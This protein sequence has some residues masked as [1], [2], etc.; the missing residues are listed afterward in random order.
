MN[1]YITL[2]A[3]LNIAHNGSTLLVSGLFQNS[4][5]GTTTCSFAGSY[6]QSGRIGDVSG[7]FTCVS[8]EQGNFAL[9]RV[10]V[11]EN[12]MLASAA[13]SSY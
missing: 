6:A 4:R 10:E 13:Y 12:G 9:S 5:G 8:G 7:T 11:T 3:N 1:G 2:I